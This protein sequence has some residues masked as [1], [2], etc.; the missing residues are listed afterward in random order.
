MHT[1]PSERDE[2]EVL[3]VAEVRVKWGELFLDLSKHH[4]MKTYPVLN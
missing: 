2:L 3:D 4:A 1:N